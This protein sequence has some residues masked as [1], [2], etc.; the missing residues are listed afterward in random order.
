MTNGSYGVLIAESFPS[1][2]RYSGMGLSYSLGIAIFG[3]MA[4]L[5]FTYFL[6]VFATPKA[7][8]Y[9]LVFTAALALM[10]V[11]LYKQNLGLAKQIPLNG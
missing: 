7:P 2:T 8:S 1:N 5:M 9:Y 11:L 4:P 6:N 3:G 10:G